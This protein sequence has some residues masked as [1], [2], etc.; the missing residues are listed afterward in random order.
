MTNGSKLI[1]LKIFNRLIDQ[2]LMAGPLLITFM[3]DKVPQKN[4]ENVQS[5]RSELEMYPYKT[6]FKNLHTDAE[7]KF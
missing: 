2:F 4:C 5:Y 1:A 6:S 7:A 3:A